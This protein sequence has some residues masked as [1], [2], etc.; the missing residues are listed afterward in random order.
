MA[1]LCSVSSYI[2]LEVDKAK[3][4]TLMQSLADWEAGLR[5]DPTFRSN[6]S[7]L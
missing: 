2:Q 1:D 4:L 5:S 6:R 3:L 7:I